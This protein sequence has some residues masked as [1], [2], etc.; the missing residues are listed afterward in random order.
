MR[1]TPRLWRNAEH[2]PI[3]VDR[4]PPVR[5]RGRRDEAPVADQLR[6]AAAEGGEHHFVR[7][8]QLQQPAVVDDPELIAE[9]LRL[10]EV[11]GHEDPGCVALDGGLDREQA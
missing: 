10:G 7:A 3:G 4:E 8:A 6:H 9:G 5:R 2:D 11:M 1:T